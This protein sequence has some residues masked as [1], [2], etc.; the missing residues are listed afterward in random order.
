MSELLTLVF[1]E[2]QGHIFLILGLM[3]MEQIRQKG[4]LKNQRT[5]CK[6]KFNL[7]ESNISENARDIEIGKISQKEMVNDIN[8]IKIDVKAIKVKLEDKWGNEKDE[9]KEAA[10]KRYGDNRL[11]DW[12]KP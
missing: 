12:A 8:E 5:E 9:E 4:E 7:I 2:F 1:G 6:G 11:E 3:Y 10:Q